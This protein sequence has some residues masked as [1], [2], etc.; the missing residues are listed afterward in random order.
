MSEASRATQLRGARRELQ[1]I[2]TVKTIRL[3]VFV[4]YGCRR[5]V[6]NCD[7]NVIV[8][9]FFEPVANTPRRPVS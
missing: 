5:L 4:A 1:A 9:T 6:L 7:G 8:S 3:S 2:A